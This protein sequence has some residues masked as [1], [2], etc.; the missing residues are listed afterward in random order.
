[1]NYEKIDNIEIGDLNFT[2]YPDFVDAFIVSADY[3]GVEM[4]HAQLDD[5]N[6]DNDF[7]YEAVMAKL[8]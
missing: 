4:T 8:F 3:D 5:I 6:E 7:V 2:D 1:M